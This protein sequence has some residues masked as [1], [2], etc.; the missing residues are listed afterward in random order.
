MTQED[1]A[2]LAEIDISFISRMERGLTQ[3]SIG[4]LIKLA[5]VLDTTAAKLMAETEKALAAR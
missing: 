1:L 4:V 2:H 5:G 3:P